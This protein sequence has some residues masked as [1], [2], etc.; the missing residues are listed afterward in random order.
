MENKEEVR[1]IYIT[2][3]KAKLEEL[4]ELTRLIHAL[5]D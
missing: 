4:N 1:E 3:W 5:G 2:K